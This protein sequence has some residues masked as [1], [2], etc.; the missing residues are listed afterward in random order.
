M[1]FVRVSGFSQTDIDTAYNNGYAAGR[2]SASP[3]RKSFYF[4]LSSG[5]TY[6]DSWT[7][8]KSGTLNIYWND[9]C[10]GGSN[11]WSLTVGGSYVIN[12]GTSDM[13]RERNKVQFTTASVTAGQTISISAH[14]DSGW[15]CKGTV[16][17]ILTV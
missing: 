14:S 10:G 6:S 7:A 1:A 17:I 9:A 16:Y 11:G 15:Y 8:P 4:D 5:A 2:T 12:R 13:D 3:S